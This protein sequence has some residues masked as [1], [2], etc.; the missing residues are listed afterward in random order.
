MQ[1]SGMEELS[2][3]SV[4]LLETALATAQDAQSS[5]IE[6]GRKMATSVGD[7]VKDNPWRAMAVLAGAGLLLAALMGRR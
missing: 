2:R 6:A 7:Y 4:T 3:K 5:T 1:E